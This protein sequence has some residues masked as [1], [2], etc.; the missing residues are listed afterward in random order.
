[1]NC[2][3]GYKKVR[4]EKEDAENSPTWRAGTMKN[5]LTRASMDVKQMIMMMMYLSLAH[6]I[7]TSSSFIMLRTY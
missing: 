2:V 5:R 4:V 3:G 7:S 1:M 6:F